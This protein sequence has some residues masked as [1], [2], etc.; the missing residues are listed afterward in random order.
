MSINATI[1]DTTY[2]GIE[3][4]NAFGNTIRLEEVAE[5][6]GGSDAGA[7]TTWDDS[8]ECSFGGII[9]KVREAKATG[10]FAYQSISTEFVQMFDT[11]LGD[12]WNGIVIIDEEGTM[13]S[14][15]PTKYMA[16]FEFVSKEFSMRINLT[17][18]TSEAGAKDISGSDNYMKIEN[19]V[20]YAKSRYASD[21]Y[22][23]FVVGHTY[24]WFAW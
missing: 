15:V 17:A 6:T 21:G 11:G 24:R 10:T 7:V 3:T 2:E 18:N 14:T 1:D 23:P 20:Y 8:S 9:K 13:P 4:I 22:Q 12:N 16:W 5:S 19:G